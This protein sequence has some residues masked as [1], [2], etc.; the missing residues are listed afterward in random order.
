MPTFGVPN[1][2]K[3]DPNGVK[4][5]G[6]EANGTGILVHEFYGFNTTQGDYYLTY[7]PIGDGTQCVP[8]F[9]TFMSRSLKLQE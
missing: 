1:G 6:G 7:T 8:L 4:Y 3:C 2:A 5:L 9:F